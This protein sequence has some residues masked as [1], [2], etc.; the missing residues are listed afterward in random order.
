MFSAVTH[1]DE[2]LGDFR[3]AD[4]RTV[5][6]Q[7]RTDIEKYVDLTAIDRVTPSSG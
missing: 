2:D 5:S 6:V 1:C 4:R 3:G 7:I